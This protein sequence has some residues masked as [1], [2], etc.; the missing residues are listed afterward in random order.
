[1][2]RPEVFFAGSSKK[3]LPRKNSFFPKENTRKLYLIGQCSGCSGAACAKW[4]VRRR[5]QLHPACPASGP[6]LRRAVGTKVY[7]VIK[8]MSP[9]FY[10][11]LQHGWLFSEQY[12]G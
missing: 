4:M 5:S 10:F 12:R 1:M 3:G 11:V 2:L 9:K 7:A 6:A 8:E